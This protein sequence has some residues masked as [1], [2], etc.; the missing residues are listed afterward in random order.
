LTSPVLQTGS[1]VHYDAPGSTRNLK[2][3]RYSN[4]TIGSTGSA[5]YDLPAA[6]LDING[7]LRL[8]GGTLRITNAQTITLSGSWLQRS[9]ATFTRGTGTV[10]LNGMGRSVTLSGSSTFNNLTID[11]GLVGYWRFDEGAGGS[12][13]LVK[14]SSRQGNHGTLRNSNGTGYVANPTHTGSFFNP[15]ALDF[16]GLND[17]VDLGTPSS[18][19]LATSANSVTVAVW[20]NLSTTPAARTGIVSFGDSNG[21]YWAATLGDTDSGSRQFTYYFDSNGNA[22]SHANTAIPIGEWHHVALTRS[23]GGAVAFYYDGAADGTTSGTASSPA[24]GTK[25]IGTRLEGPT[26]FPGILDDVR[27]YNRVLSAGEVR[28]LALGNQTTG[29]GVYVLARPLAVAGNLRIDAGTLDVSSSNYGVTVSGSWVNH[30]GFTRRSGTVTLDGTSEFLSGSTVFNNLTKTVT[31]ADTL[32]F[33]HSAMQSVSGALTLRGVAGN[34]LSLRSSKT[35]SASS[36]RLEASGGTQTIDY[37]DVQDSDAGGG[38]LLRCQT[39]C[40]DSGNNTNWS[41][42]APQRI[43]G[44]AYSDEG[45]VA[46]TSRRIAASING[47]SAYDADVTTSTGAFT[48]SGVTL[49]GGTIITLY[50]DN[51]AENAVTVLISSG[52]SM[53]SISLYQ[54]RLLVQSVTGG[55]VTNTHLATADNNGD[56]DITTIIRSASASALSVSGAELLVWAGTTFAPGGSVSAGSGVDVNGTLTLGSN[57]LTLSGSFDATGGSFT[58]SNLVTFDGTSGNHTIAS[59]GRTFSGVTIEGAGTYTASGAMRLRGGLTISAGTLALGNNPLTVSGSFNNTG[60]SFTTSALLTFNGTSGSHTIRGNGASFTGITLA[61]SATWSLGSALTMRGNLQ[62]ESGT[63]NIS[64][65]NY[66]VTFSGSWLNRGTFVAGSGTVTLDGVNQTLSGTTQFWNLQKIATRLDTLRF[67]VSGQ[68]TVSGTLLLSGSGYTARMRILSERAGSAAILR[69]D[70]TSG[71]DTL[72]FLTV[73]DS[74]A[75]GGRTLRCYLSCRDLDNNTNWDFPNLTVQRI[76]GRVY[77]EDRTTAVAT[78]TPVVWR[79]NAGPIVDIDETDATGAYTLSGAVM[80]GGSL[81]MLYVPGTVTQRGV[82]ALIASGGTMSGVDLYRNHLIVRSESGSAAMGT[83]H[84]RQMYLSDTN[85]IDDVFSMSTNN[86]TLKSGQKLL[87]WDSD[88]FEADGSVSTPSTVLRGSYN[89][90]GNAFTTSELELQ[91]GASFTRGGGSVDINGPLTL[92]GGTFHHGTGSITISGNIRMTP[93][94]TFNRARDGTPLILDGDLT[95]E[96][97][98]N[99]QTNFGHVL[100]GSSPDTTTLSGNLLVDRLRIYAGDTLI[101]AGYDI[102]IGTGGLVNSGTLIA[103]AGVG[104]TTEITNASGA[105]NRGTYTAGNS[106]LTLSGNF[107]NSGTFEYGTSTVALDGLGQTVSGTTTFYNLEKKLPTGSLTEG[108]RT[109]IF[110]AGQTFTVKNTA[111]LEGNAANLL[112]L[113]SSTLGTQWKFDPSGTRSISYVD[114]EDSNNISATFIDPPNSVNAGNTTRWFSDQEAAAA[115]APVESGGEGHRGRGGGGGRGVPIVTGP[116]EEPVT[117]T[118]APIVLR[119]DVR[120]RTWGY[121]DREEIEGR[122]PIT[123]EEREEGL[124]SIERERRERERRL[125]RAARRAEE[126]GEII[127]EL[128]PLTIV[129][130]LRRTRRLSDRAAIR[131]VIPT[132]KIPPSLLEPATIERTPWYWAAH[133]GQWVSDIFAKAPFGFLQMTLQPIIALSEQLQQTTIAASIVQS[134]QRL[135]HSLLSPVSTTIAQLLDRSGA[136]E[137]ISEFAVESVGQFLIIRTAVTEALENLFGQVS[138]WRLAREIKREEELKLYATSLR[139]LGEEAYEIDQFR[140]A[141]RG[142]LGVRYAYVPVTLFSVPQRSRTDSEGIA[143]FRR[144]PTG[145][146]DLFVQLDDT[147]TVSRSVTIEAPSELQVEPEEPVEVLIPLVNVEVHEQ[148]HAAA[149][150][151]RW[152]PHWK[153]TLLSLLTLL[154]SLTGGWWIMWKRRQRSQDIDW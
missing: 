85:G 119:V 17:F 71:R 80:T 24:T 153:G 102:T 76:K 7:D 140:I 106:T 146:H 100:V 1:T 9:G 136:S 28:T 125:A 3:F 81:V 154:L 83:R 97:E 114:V 91:S 43:T 72:R 130:N 59:N 87:V 141:I 6:T 51:E 52:S 53:S 15:Y 13:A 4:L 150:E 16:D 73:R 104:G 128:S 74:N 10:I 132:A 84:L 121:E 61:G 18:L 57:P 21:A 135:A 20:L 40:V 2:D 42:A 79:R 67:S 47:G 107:V 50:L 66:A 101:T 129:E 23:V 12:G 111:T 77:E 133:L 148:L 95:L 29:S 65:S 63:L 58:S 98:T 56:S 68:Q 5:I 25:T 89:L 49:T 138:L 147:L 46:L 109:L 94:A 143:E 22:G 86:L 120:E 113:R 34:R 124:P 123:L 32:T 36:V 93:N 30:G 108:E 64:S 144:V 117:A 115:P 41:F 31:S 26:Y 33:D 38:A 11:N 88:T 126:R 14:D 27:V 19:N 122:V 103:S 110:G 45:T 96:D 134:M 92:L 39:G 78:G 90:R 8:S 105:I 62:I 127:E 116:T 70:S 99:G 118:E 152:T 60:G 69:V 139:K 35:G 131:Q 54:N 145:V 112:R 82:V 55:T 151:R 137:G 48:L 44:T 37:L 75:A 149:P 142:P